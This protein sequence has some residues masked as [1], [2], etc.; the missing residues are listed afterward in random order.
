MVAITPA[1]SK[2]NILRPLREDLRNGLARDL[3]A[4]RNVGADHLSFPRPVIQEL[5]QGVE[6]VQFHMNP[7]A[8]LKRNYI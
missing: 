1:R 2:L 4:L 7:K 8:L 6:G 3:G 5:D